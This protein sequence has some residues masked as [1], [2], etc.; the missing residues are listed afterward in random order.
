MS[1]DDEQRRTRLAM[2]ARFMSILGNV[3]ELCDKS[4][5]PETPIAKHLEEFVQSIKDI[6][7]DA[8]LVMSFLVWVDKIYK[9]KKD[10]DQFNHICAALKI[11]FNEHDQD[12]F[13]VLN[14][15]DK[16]LHNPKAVSNGKNR[17]KVI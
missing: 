2:H 13:N 14:D 6:P 3:K 16:K 4:Y 1:F 17:Y 10:D 12:V 7:I 11:L 9:G 8:K 5:L 15:L